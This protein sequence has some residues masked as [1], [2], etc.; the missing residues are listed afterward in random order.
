LAP[1]VDAD[2]R[3]PVSTGHKARYARRLAFTDLIVLL[4][5]MAAAQLARFGLETSAQTTMEGG[6]A[7]SYP[8]VGVILAVG[9]W[10]LLQAHQTRNPAIVGHG[11]EEYR[12][13]VVAT[14]RAFALL[15][16]LSLAFKV[17][18]SRLYLATAFPLGLMGLL[19]GRKLSRRALHAARAQGRALTKVLVVGGERSAT[20]LAQW[21]DRHPAAGYQVSGV[22]VP[23]SAM[24][25]RAMLAVSAQNVPVMSAGVGFEAAL[26][27]SGASA[28]VV[29]DTE[30]LGHETL[31]DMTWQLEGTGTE[32][33]LSPNVLGVSSARLQMNDVSGMPLIRLAEPQFANAGRR[34]KM[35]FDR[36]GSL[37]LI[38][39][40]SPVL[41]V[42]AALVKLTSRGP[43]FYRQSRVGRH[44]QSFDMIK[45]RSM[46]VGADSE[47]AALLAA[48]GKTLAHLPKLDRDPRVTS[49]GA[50]IRRYSIDELPQLFNVLRGDMSLVGPRPQR[51]FEVEQYDDEAT[52]RL[53]VRPGM[54]GLWQV[55]GRSDLTFDEAIKL[56][57][58]YVENW[59]MTTDL[60]ILW[61]TLRAVVASDGAY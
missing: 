31:R 38:V 45:F 56:D 47:L 42:V 57:V 48:E 27:A 5:A 30:H 60:V 6:A 22:W 37:L 49:V 16:M 19:V 39:A 24:P 10:I 18:A 20:R 9:W 32:F 36:M 58:H 50:F 1:V 43:V 52:R 26:S 41:L 46:R 54:T 55:S 14:F 59:S 15:A 34:G 28:V 17:D 13:V 8:V 4:G 11:S 33:M 12:R 25:V 44:G 61:R 53:T 23:D 35:W 21:F 29:T 40:F 7:F 51:D 2:T 3:G